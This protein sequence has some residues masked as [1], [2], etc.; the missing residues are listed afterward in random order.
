MAKRRLRLGE[1][2]QRSEV[3]V[4][5]A[6][7]ASEQEPV[8]HHDAIDGA[9]ADHKNADT[10]GKRQHLA[11]FDGHPGRGKSEHRFFD[12]AVGGQ[13]Q[14]DHGDRG[15]VA[16]VLEAGKTPAHAH[17]WRG[18]RPMRRPV[19][20]TGSAAAPVMAQTANTQAAN[21]KTNR[22]KI[23]KTTPEG[24]P[25]GHPNVCL[26]GVAGGGNGTSVNLGGRRIAGSRFREHPACGP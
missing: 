22:R 25:A 18:R 14:F 2:D 15:L 11:L 9:L 1:R 19:G 24:V 6:E 5:A 21:T 13:R 3:G 26:D 4:G 17:A 7:G 23:I 20:N 8:V 10:V 12:A 16:G